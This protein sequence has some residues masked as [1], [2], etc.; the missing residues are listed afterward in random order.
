MP[1]ACYGAKPYETVLH[2]IDGQPGIILDTMGMIRD[3]F[4]TSRKYAVALLEYLDDRRLT[5]RVGDS[6]VRGPGARP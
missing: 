2:A 5:R 6:R 4:A 3:R 1:D